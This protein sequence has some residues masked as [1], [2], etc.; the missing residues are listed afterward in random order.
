MARKSQ[1]VKNNKRK[2]LVARY[3]EKRSKLVAI[4][5]DPHTSSEEKVQAQKQLAKLP[6][7]SSATRVRN[8]CALTGRARGYMSFFDMSRLAFRELAHKG[9][10]P[11]VKKTSW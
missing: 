9:V 6:R 2:V 10:L 8:R 5:K 1:I 3:A 7:S 4:V 11:G